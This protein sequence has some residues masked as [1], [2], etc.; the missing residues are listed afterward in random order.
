MKKPDLVGGKYPEYHPSVWQPT[1]IAPFDS[2]FDLWGVVFGSYEYPMLRVYRQE[3][4]AR[5]QAQSL[6][7]WRQNGHRAPLRHTLF[8]PYRPCLVHTSQSR[9]RRVSGVPLTLRQYVNREFL[10]LHSPAD[11]LVQ[12]QPV[13]SAPASGEFFYTVKQSLAEQLARYKFGGDVVLDLAKCTAWEQLTLP[14]RMALLT[15]REHAELKLFNALPRAASP[16]ELVY[17]DT[18]TDVQALRQTR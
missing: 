4:E 16:K 5:I 14:E 6:E 3:W 1:T 8:V 2:R 13:T 18:A 12:S 15:A 10:V 7:L 11:V 17:H 9:P